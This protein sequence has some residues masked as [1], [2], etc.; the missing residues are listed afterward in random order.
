M[1]ALVWLIA[2]IMLVGVEMFIGELTFLMLGGGAL[3]AA[4]S[5]LATDTWW[6]H[7]LVFASVSVGLLFFVKPMLKKRMAVPTSTRGTGARELVGETALV[8]EPTSAHAGMIRLAGELWSARTL[9]P[10]EC[11]EPDDTVHVLRID[12]A[13]AVVWKEK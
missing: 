12:G 7:L 1:S 4:A 8:V 13:T 11:Y 3:A 9:D 5:A 2:G 10:A 6:V